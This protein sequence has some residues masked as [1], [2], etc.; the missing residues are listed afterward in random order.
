M[1]NKNEVEIQ[2]LKRELR[3]VKQQIEALKQDESRLDNELWDAEMQRD[4]SV[5]DG[6]AAQ[7]LADHKAG[8]TLPMDT[9]WDDDI[10]M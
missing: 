3:E 7:A 4:A 5:L 2:R 6:L 10:G 9:L 8:L 1:A